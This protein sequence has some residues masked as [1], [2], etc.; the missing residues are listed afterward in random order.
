MPTRKIARIKIG[1]GSC[2]HRLH[3]FSSP[4][5]LSV[6]AAERSSDERLIRLLIEQALELGRIGNLDL[7]EPALNHW[8]AIDQRRLIDD[9]LIDLDDFAAHRR[10]NV[11]GG[12]DGLD[13]RRRGSLFWSRARR[14]Q[15][16]EDKIAE[17][18]LGMV[19]D[20]NSG[21][22]AFDTKPFMVFREFRHRA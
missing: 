17:L 1:G 10:I 2:K 11:R 16:N 18:F 19:R 15:F 12:L 13:N 14:R 7:E 3:L 21:D 9:S 22:I 6:I 8:I 20:A 5:S 4:S